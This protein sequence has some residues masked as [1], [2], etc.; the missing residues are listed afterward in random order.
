[1]QLRGWYAGALTL[2]LAAAALILRPATRVAVAVYAVF[3]TSMVLG[4]GPL[5]T[6]L[7]SSV[8]GFDTAHNQRMLIYVL[9]AL[10]LLAGFGLDDLSDGRLRSAVRAPPR[11]R[12]VG[13]H[14]RGARALD[15]GRRDADDARARARA[16]RRLGLREPAVGRPAPERHP[17]RR[18]RPDERAAA[19]APAGRRRP[20]PR[21]AAGAARAPAGGGA[22]SSRSPSSC[23]PSTC[24][25]P[26]WAS[27][28]RSR[29]RT[30]SRPATGAIAELQAPGAEPLR[31]DRQDVLASSRCRPTCRCAT[32]STTR[33]ATTT[34]RRSGTT[35]SGGA[36]CAP[37]VPR[38]HAADRRWP[39]GPRPRCARSSLLSV[40]DVLQETGD[41]PP[42][43]PGLRVAYT[44][45]RRDRLPQHPRAP[46]H[47]PRRRAAPRGRR[48]RRAGHGDRPGL[49][50]PRRG[51]HRA[52]AGRDPRR[53]RRARRRPRPHA[54]RPLR[55]TS[56]RRSTCGRRGAA[57]SSSR[58]S[59]SRA[60]RPPSTARRGPHRARG[61]P[62][63]RRRGAARRPPR[64]VHATQPK[65]FRVGWI[66]SLLAALAVLAVVVAELLRRR[67]ARPPAPETAG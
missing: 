28:R 29:P 13:R 56:G 34:P 25:G 37:G 40:S 66:I 39:P 44:R 6:F 19:V 53:G 16:R 32:A 51:R 55:A 22:P 60:G 15:G 10:A 2:M 9:L 63:A 36:A 38:L 45:P 41:P 59:T 5:F 21:G 7:T 26:T 8:P 30:P 57:S 47:V 58:T 20:R 49:R 43:A 23:C 54:P 18:H 17:P 31:G 27:T 50:R 4:L 64:R 42:A 62:P 14:P 11:G 65:S 61:L 35:V 1:M 52:A 33:A 24:S 3:C 46:A 67:R 12:R 48:G